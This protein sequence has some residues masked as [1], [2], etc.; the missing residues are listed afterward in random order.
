MSRS[1]RGL[2]DPPRRGRGF[3]PQSGSSPLEPLLEYGGALQVEAGQE[4]TLVQSQ[5]LLISAPGQSCEEGTGVAPQT[6]RI[7]PQLLVA[8]TQDHLPSK[9]LPEAVDDLVQGVSAPF[10]GDVGPDPTQERVATNEPWFPT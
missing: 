10:V 2:R 5:R 1:L 3:V 9:R 7:D 8:T 6:V 4:L